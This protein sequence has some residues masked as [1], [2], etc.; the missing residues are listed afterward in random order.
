[1]F[2]VRGLG[3]AVGVVVNPCPV[4]AK[5]CHPT[6][7]PSRTIDGG[8]THQIPSQHADCC[9]SL[10]VPLISAIRELIPCLPC[11]TLSI[12]SGSGLLESLILQD[13][14]DLGLFGVEISTRVNRYLPRDRLHVVKGTW[15]LDPAACS[16]EGWLFVYPRE[17]HLLHKYL[18]GYGRGSVRKVIWLGPRADLEEY[19]RILEN[20]QSDWKKEEVE[21]CGLVLYEQLIVWS[22]LN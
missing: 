6:S 2:G 19:A 18:E 8:L 1:M 11:T 17:P 4:S 3:G 22:K 7:N 12:G 9:V 5:T 10:S 13:H 21:D 16:A 15:D 20:H 14:G